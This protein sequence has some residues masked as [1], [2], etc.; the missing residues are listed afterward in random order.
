VYPGFTTQGWVQR[1]YLG[2]ILVIKKQKSNSGCGRLNLLVKLQKD[3]L[4]FGLIANKPLVLSIFVLLTLELL[5]MTK[6]ILL[7]SVNFD[8]WKVVIA[9]D[10][11]IIK[12]YFFIKH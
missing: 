6:L 5:K 12:N 9:R 2:E 8:G 4:R 3:L 7:I 1:I 11:F 10:Y